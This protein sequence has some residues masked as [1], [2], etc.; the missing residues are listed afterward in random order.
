MNNREKKFAAKIKTERQV[1]AL[2]KDRSVIILLLLVTTSLCACSRNMEPKAEAS[3]AA[4]APLVKTVQSRQQPLQNELQVVGNLAGY[5][6]VIVSSQVEGP[7]KR[8]VHDLGDSV[9]RGTVL[10]EIDPTELNMQ[11]QR[12]QASYR[13][14]LARLGI[15]EGS[16]EIPA[17]ENTAEV[18]QAKAELDDAN[19]KVRRMESLLQRGVVSQQ[20]VDDA[21]TTQKVAAARYQA[22]IQ[23]V[24]NMIASAH[25][26]RAALA[27]AHKKVQ[28]TA[29]RSPIGGIVQEKLV[30]IGEVVKVNQSMFKLVSVQPL[31]FR[32]Q[33]MEKD[34]PLVHSGAR[35][36]IAVDAVPG[37]QFP[38]TVHRLAPAVEEKT[39]TF[40]VEAI[41]PNPGGLLKP[42][43]FARCIIPVGSYTAV[44]AP[45]E[46]VITIAGLKKIYVIENGVAQERNV[47]VGRAEQNWVEIKQGLQPREYVAV[48][49]L[50]SLSNGL[51]V[52]TQ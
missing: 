19:T 49:N 52:Q 32:A 51:K 3:R 46:A 42:G 18:R 8:I 50:Q 2:G 21:H 9:S 6:E 38:G 25:Q 24:Q 43:F 27:W 17:F 44:L 47:E 5:E 26:F 16:E 11:L 28:D 37:R 20:A 45:R 10:A 41:I 23:S 39:R 13:E 36:D 22:A 14:V 34:A 48:S 33:V 29:V 7:V 30:S 31:K 1:R 12:A 35:V 4:L 15:P 40:T